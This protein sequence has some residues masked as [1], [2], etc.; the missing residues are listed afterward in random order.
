MNDNP[1]LFAAEALILAAVLVLGT[2]FACSSEPELEFADWTFDVPESTPVHGYPELSSDGRRGD[3]VDLT[4]D[5]VIG[6]DPDD[7]RAALYQPTDL[8]TAP[9][10]TVFVADR[11]AHHINVFNPDGTWR[12]ALGKEGQGPGEFTGL[13]HITVAGGLLVAFDTRNRRFS[14]WTLAGDHVADHNP[15]VTR[16]LSSLYGLADGTLVWTYFAYDPGRSTARQ[17]A[18]HSTSA[19][20]ELDVVIEGPAVPTREMSPT[21]PV[22]TLQAMLDRLEDP[23]LVLAVGRDGA[24]YFSSAEAYQVLST[25]QDGTPRWALRRAG[26]PPSMPENAKQTLVAWILEAFGADV[27]IDEL[28]W[29][30]RIPAIFHLR[31][32]GAGR[33]FVFRASA[34]TGLV[35]AEMSFAPS[36]SWLVDVYGPDGAYLASGNVPALWSHSHDN[37]VYEITTDANNEPV[38][39]RY[40]LTVHAS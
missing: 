38:V 5:L 16:S 18:M 31:V 11:G 21:D 1:R 17:V 32:D 23:Q 27:G 8:T 28:S 4:V 15:E 12:Q 24:V 3:A 37:F 33:L 30:E 19:G 2:T 22:F 39:V 14:H 7:P 35:P 10:G 36:E 20:E 9:D 25:S 34:E 26:A 13:R 29:P 40:R 6:N